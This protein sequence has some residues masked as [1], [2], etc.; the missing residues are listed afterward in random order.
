MPNHGGLGRWARNSAAGPGTLMAGP[1]KGQ[2]SSFNPCSLGQGHQENAA[3]KGA[4]LPAP[5]L[6]GLRHV[7]SL[8][9]YWGNRVGFHSPYHL[10]SLWPQ[11]PTQVHL[12]SSWSPTR[13][14]HLPGYCCSEIRAHGVKWALGKLNEIIRVL[15][16][17]VVKSVNINYLR[18]V[19]I[20]EIDIWGIRKCVITSP[21]GAAWAKEWL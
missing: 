5:L 21:G 1:H 17:S 8:S 19:C 10:R 3:W 7:G 13:G 9:L 16:Q 4:F 15:Q 18:T 12:P 11:C 20:E 6:Q 2:N 14:W